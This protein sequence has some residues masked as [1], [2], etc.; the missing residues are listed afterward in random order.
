MTVEGSDSID[1]CSWYDI[2]EVGVAMNGICISVGHNGQ[3]H[4]LGRFQRTSNQTSLLI[5]VVRLAQS[6]FCDHGTILTIFE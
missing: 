6:A 3:Q 2:W 5:T 1:V 4:G